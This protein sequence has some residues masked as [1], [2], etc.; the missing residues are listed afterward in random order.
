MN[1]RYVHGT[2][3]FKAGIKKRNRLCMGMSN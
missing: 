1:T 3:N 2:I